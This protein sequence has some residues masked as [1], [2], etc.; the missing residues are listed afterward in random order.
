MQTYIATN[1]LNGKFYIGSAINFE[2]RKRQHLKSKSSRPFHADL[3]ENSKAFEWTVWTDD[4]DDSILERAL[5]EMW[6]GKE[7]CYNMSPVAME[8][9]MPIRVTNSH[10]KT[11]DYPSIQKAVRSTGV[12]RELL[13]SW[14]SGLSSGRKW[15]GWRA[16]YL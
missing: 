8:R 4:T 12:S 10:G 9:G 7:Q 11:T 13:R 5:L 15:K 16:E 14:A 2:K 1:T 6:H 3:R